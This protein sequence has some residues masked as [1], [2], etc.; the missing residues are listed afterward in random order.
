MQQDEIPQTID[1]DEESI[2]NL[3][4]ML[5]MIY[6]HQNLNRGHDRIHPL[7]FTIAEEFEESWEKPQ[8]LSPAE[9]LSANWLLRNPIAEG[10][11]F[12]PD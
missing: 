10:V 8:S 6:Y 7:I 11:W 1:L 5:G 9:N 12:S 3:T 4:L 2:Q